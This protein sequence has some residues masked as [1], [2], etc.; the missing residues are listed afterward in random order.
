VSPLECDQKLEEIIREF[1]RRIVV[2]RCSEFETLCEIA[3][4]VC[5][6]YQVGKSQV[7]TVT[8]QPTDSAATGVTSSDVPSA[9]DV[10]AQTRLP[11][12]A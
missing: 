7:I 9:V 8:D 4:R 2:P 5:E 6:H 12:A 3:T 11:I 10:P 1:T